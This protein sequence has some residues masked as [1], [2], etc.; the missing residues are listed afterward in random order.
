[1][2]ACFIT[3]KIGIACEWSRLPHLYGQ[4]VAL[5]D[6]RG[7]LSVVSTEAFPF[8]VRAGQASTFARSLCRGLI[9]LPYDQAAYRKAATAIWDAVA[10]ESSVVEPLSPEIV[11]ADIA[12]TEIAG[13]VR[14]LISILSEAVGVPVCVGIGRSKLVAEWAARQS[15]GN[16]VIISSGKERD[17][18]AS[19]TLAGLPGIKPA[20]AERAQ[21]LSVRTLGEFLALP[22]RE[23]DR[24]FG[25]VAHRLRRLSQGDDGEP[26]RALWPPRV[27]EH[28]IGFDDEVGDEAVLH[29]ALRICAER[30]AE[31]LGADRQYCRTLTLAVE[32]ASGPL[33][34]REELSG[35]T[36]DGALL[37]RAAVRLFSRL[38]IA[39]PVT[40][41][42]LS[43]AEI[44]NGRSV[45][46]AFLDEDDALSSEARKSLDAAVAHIKE[47]YGVRAVVDGSLAYQARRTYLW[48]YALGHVND[49]A[50]EVVIGR[51]GFPTRFCRRQTMREYAVLEVQNSWRE[52]DWSLG[53]LSEKSCYRVLTDPYGLYELH[54]TS[55]QWRLLAAAD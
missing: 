16:P 13:R 1:M 54:E 52:T 29:A 18:L 20:V 48:T 7:I 10:V 5:R 17:L 44:T 3:E 11:F 30:I 40:R 26:V 19:A 51:H 23:A 45:Q 2:I 8:G 12:G 36:H 4:P 28:A 6:D 50:V 41:V 25:Q 38:K 55:G 43:A 53:K 9:V 32:T 47:K 35:P 27:V 24:Q 15:E 49:E 21:K 14:K 31:S 34:R 39:A 22:T 37:S 42:H 46:L 33:A